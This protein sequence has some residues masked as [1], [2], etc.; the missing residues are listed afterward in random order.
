MG[1]ANAWTLASGLALA[2]AFSAANN[3]T[4]NNANNKMSLEPANDEY[5][6]VPQTFF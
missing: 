4:N 2:L 3:N 6:H 1:T 5:A